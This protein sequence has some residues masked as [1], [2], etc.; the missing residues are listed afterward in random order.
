MASSPPAPVI[1]FKDRVYILDPP[2]KI[3]KIEGHG[4]FDANDVSAAKIVPVERKR[5]PVPNQFL[6]ETH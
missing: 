3:Q 5:S 6:C 2:V 1:K 4:A